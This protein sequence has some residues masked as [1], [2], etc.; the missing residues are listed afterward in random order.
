MC[1][2]VHLL[3]AVA[4]A[5]V[6]TV[7]HDPVDTSLPGTLLAH[8][9]V[10]VATGAPAFTAL[11]G[12]LLG[13]LATTA[14][15]VATVLELP[16]GVTGNAGVHAAPVAWASLTLVGRRLLTPLLSTDVGSPEP[17]IVDVA[18]IGGAHGEALVGTKEALLAAIALH[19]STL[20]AL[21][22]NL[23]PAGPWD[24]AP[25]VISSPS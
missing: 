11:L 16:L 23:A 8:E 14:H 13:G 12:S 25:A 6:V 5:G 19:D 3:L 21:G 7:L 18:G 15:V 1:K 10:G 4:L 9:L 20:V 24:A 2:I 17:L 22:R